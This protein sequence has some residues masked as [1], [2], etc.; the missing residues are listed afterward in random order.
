MHGPM[1]MPTSMSTSIRSAVILVLTLQ[2]GLA[3]PALRA[4]QPAPRPQRDSAAKDSVR[5]LPPDNYALLPVL[6]VF[7]GAMLVVPPS[8]LLPVVP[9]NLAPGELG[10]WRDH[11]SV[12]VSGGSAFGEDARARWAHSESVE[13]LRHG[14]LAEAGV[15]NLSLPVYA[16]YRSA[17]LGYLVH[18]KPT[19]AG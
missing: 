4:Q 14:V 7:A 19:L 5:L 13:L 16:Q 6:A 11:V 15:E 18:P 1:P 12:A 10:F 17:R 9:T 8:I 2:T 3:T